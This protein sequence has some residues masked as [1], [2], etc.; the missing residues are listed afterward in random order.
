M[1]A[2]RPGAATPGGGDAPILAAVLADSLSLLRARRPAEALALIARLPPP[3]AADPRI[4]ARLGYAHGLMGRLAEALAAARAAL[5][6]GRADL[7]SLDLA[8][9]TFTLCHRP[10]EAHAAFE[11]AARIAPESPAVLYNLA[12]TARFVGRTQEAERAYDRVIAAAP[13]AWEAYRNRSELR[14]QTAGRN[15]VRE[16]TA[17]LARPDLPWRG[18]VQLRYALGKELEDLQD[19][20]RAFENF[21][22]GAQ[23][24]R[25][26]MRYDV[27][28]DVAAM[29][30]IG[31]TFDKAWCA[32]ALDVPEPGPAGPIFILGLPRTGS[33]L[34]ERMLGRHSQVQPLGELQ[35]FGGALTEV[36]RRAARPPPAG[37]AGMI[38]ASAALAPDAVGAAYLAATAPLRDARPR[39]IDKLPINVL[40]AGLIA[41]ALPSASIVHLT[42]DPLDTCVAI[43]KTLFEEAYP[44]SYDL[45]ELGAYYNAY[46][47]LAAHW[48]AALGPRLIE[49]AYEDLVSDPAAVMGG[50]MPRLGLAMEAACLA[51]EADASPVMTAS[52]SQVRKPIH[53]R[54]AGSASR[55]RARLGPLLAVLE[56]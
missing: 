50:L 27:A 22:R 10:Q 42:R 3:M 45:A 2:A 38:Q 20:D 28:D 37:K 1:T 14:R 4:A 15:H 26:H 41:R 11:R 17:A 49:V 33:T 29:A 18:E 53:A 46:R 16:L 48:R 19:Y 40:Y 43:Y 5:A 47:R 21:E 13:D 23:A 7:A 52:A 32:P 34:L 36:L 55:Y 44:Y 6:S 30:L 25:T 35:A 8:G 9:N 51:P 56:T 39:F 12:A 24:R 31:R 54:S